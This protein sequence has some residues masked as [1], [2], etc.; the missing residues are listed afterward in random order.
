VPVE[1]AAPARAALAVSGQPVA[2]P[3]RVR[4]VTDRLI[5]P[6]KAVPAEMAIHLQAII[7]QAQRATKARVLTRE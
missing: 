1:V 7:L 4:P 5:Q 3:V 6:I 2:L